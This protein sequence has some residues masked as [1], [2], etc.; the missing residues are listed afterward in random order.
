MNQ[1]ESINTISFGY[2]S[3][4]DNFRNSGRKLETMA[5]FNND[6]ITNAECNFINHIY[7]IY[8]MQLISMKDSGRYTSNPRTFQGQGD[9]YGKWSNSFQN[10][11][12]KCAFYMSILSAHTCTPYQSSL[13]YLW[14]LLPR[15]PIKQGWKSLYFCVLN[16]GSGLMPHGIPGQVSEAK[17]HRFYC[18]WFFLQF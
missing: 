18:F 14:A 11:A 4:S 2:S 3:F 12:I 15:T 5:F 17:P 8:F 6:I 1:Y 13:S 10:Q 7:C 9:F 16:N